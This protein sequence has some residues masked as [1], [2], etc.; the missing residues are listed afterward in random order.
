MCI[1]AENYVD[2]TPLS[3][4]PHTLVSTN[5]LNTRKYL[6]I[7]FTNTP[8]NTFHHAHCLFVCVAW[9]QA[10]FF[11]EKKI[12]KITK[13]DF[14]ISPLVAEAMGQFKLAWAP[15]R[16]MGNFQPCL[17]TREWSVLASSV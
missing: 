9:T 2:E 17:A 7:A 3:F 8:L 10:A 11:L 5:T 14:D 12:I 6:N 1:L 15:V 16:V 4:Y 13:W